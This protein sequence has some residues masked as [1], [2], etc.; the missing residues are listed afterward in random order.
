[1]S[2]RLS[3]ASKQ[4]RRKRTFSRFR[5]SLRSSFS[6]ART[7]L[8]SLFYSF[9]SYNRSS[10]REETCVDYSPTFE[11]VAL[12]R[13]NGRGYGGRRRT[14]QKLSRE[15]RRYMESRSFLSLS[16]PPV[17]PSMKYP[18]R[19]PLNVL[20]SSAPLSASTPSS[21]AFHLL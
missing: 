8:Y 16:L 20:H 14:I 9:T 10:K 2:Y 19:G 15:I 6:S 17:V 18:L 21:L 13:Y 7:C 3:D 5:A 1:M 12:Q 11:S 4:P